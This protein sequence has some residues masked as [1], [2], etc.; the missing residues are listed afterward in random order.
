MNERIKRGCSQVHLSKKSVTNVLYQSCL[1]KKKKL[2][3]KNFP[4][5]NQ[6]QILISIT[7]TQ[8]YKR[9]N[10]FYPLERY[11]M[12]ERKEAK[13]KERK[14]EIKDTSEHICTALINNQ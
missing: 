3:T 7:N 4:N 11:S 9:D 2:V 12:S 8:R 14:K 10:N 5:K 1:N 6:N 13:R